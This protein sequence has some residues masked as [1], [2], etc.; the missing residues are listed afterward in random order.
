MIPAGKVERGE[1][2]IV[3]SI[4]ATYGLALDT[5]CDVMSPLPTVACG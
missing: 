2:I 3:D 1:E 4:I 5:L